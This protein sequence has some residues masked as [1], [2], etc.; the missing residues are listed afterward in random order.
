MTKKVA[1]EEFKKGISEGGVWVLAEASDLMRQYVQRFFPDTYEE[2]IKKYR[3]P[4]KYL[5]EGDRIVVVSLT[6]NLGCGVEIYR[7]RHIIFRE[8][9][10]WG[11]Q[12]TRAKALAEKAVYGPDYFIDDESVW[13]TDERTGISQTKHELDEKRFKEAVLAT[14]YVTKEEYERYMNGST[15]GL[16]MIEVVSN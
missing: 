9:P 13:I 7:M 2:E 3:I 5:K 4:Q 11:V 16:P 15:E 10:E 1:L 12:V 14:G 6:R 8:D